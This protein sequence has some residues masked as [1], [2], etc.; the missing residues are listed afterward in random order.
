MRELRV[1][2]QFS[3]EDRR[4]VGTLAE[5]EHDVWFQYDEAFRAAGL[6]ISR[7][8]LPLSRAGLLRH[9]VKAGVPVP[10]VFNDARPDGWGLKLLHRAFQA[11]GR[12]VSSVSPL[13]DLAFL[14][15]RTMGAL[16]F[17]PST[18]PANDLVDAVELA[19]LA[20]HAQLVWDD[21]VHD[22]LPELVRAGGPSGGARP[23]ALIGLR[24][25][26]RA[27]V[28]YGE[29]ELPEGWAAWL[30]KFPTTRDDADAG[31]R[32]HAWMAMAR[33]AG[34]EVPDCKVLPL[35]GVGDTF[36][37]RRFDRGPANRR[38]HMLSAAGALNVDFR[39]ARADYEHLIRLTLAVCGGDQSQAQAMFR[40]AAFNVASMNEDDHLKNFAFL[41]DNGGRWRLA[42][43]FDLTYSPLALGE[44]WTTVC[45]AGREIRR[46]HFATLAARAAIK[47]AVARRILNDV[48]T[49]TADVRRHL[50]DSGC[51][52]AVS[53]AA[54]AAV[55]AATARLRT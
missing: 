14:G 51:D 12:A 4:F 1:S 25:D 8:R 2:L 31:R 17:E 24:D 50:I 30:V 29:G 18:G 46:E 19:R 40:L 20:G 52:G 22:V 45:D 37:V 13:E 15:S 16:V 9:E 48:A 34:I 32:E 44:R 5:D 43:A 11:R 41:L 23:K 36:A 27:G 26:G 28:R 3:P 39:T 38:V 7:I 55:E 21:A 54:A 53:R 49:A 42:P 35:V 47:P 6:D 10:G 33:A